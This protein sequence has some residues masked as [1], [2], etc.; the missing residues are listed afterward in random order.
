MSTMERFKEKGNLVTFQK[1]MFGNRRILMQLKKYCK[2]EQMNE[3]TR[4][5]LQYKNLFLT[6]NRYG[7]RST[8]D[9]L[10]LLYVLTKKL[11]FDFSG[12]AFEFGTGSG[13]ISLLLATKIPQIKITAIEVQESLF[14]LAKENFL[15]GGIQERIVLIKMDGREIA[16]RLK[17]GMFD[18]AFS[19]PPFF[20]KGEG[21]RSPS[22]E[23]QK[24]RHEELCTMKDILASFTYL[25]KNGGRG[26]LIYPL[27]RLDE[28]VKRTQ[29]STHILL[30]EIFFYAHLK[31]YIGTWKASQKETDLYKWKKDSKLF[32]A[33]MIKK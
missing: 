5:E 21:K 33:E 2:F 22:E 23:R 12:K 7:Y 15:H 24:A 28:F 13:I 19:N 11:G 9:S 26:F 4:D 25:L 1:E 10:I 30:K 3:K 14:N 29:Q 18:C 8:E 6:Q 31:K 17:S 20:K 32:V 27:T 16:N